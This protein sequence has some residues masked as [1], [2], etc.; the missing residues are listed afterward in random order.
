[1]VI[2]RNAR[3]MNHRIIRMRPFQMI[4]SSMIL[5]FSSKGRKQT[6]TVQQSRVEWI[7]KRFHRAVV[8]LGCFAAFA[9]SSMRAGEIF[10][11]ANQLG[12]RPQDSKIGIAFSSEA[13]P[14][15]FVVISTETYKVAFEGKSESTLI[16]WGQFTNHSELDFSGLRKPGRYLLKMG[17]FGS[18]P[19]EIDP[20][21]Y[22]ALPNELLEFMRE[23]RCG[24]NPWI[25]TV[26][27]PFDGRAV[28]G[29]LTNGTY[30]DARGGWHDAADLLKYL[31]TSGNATAQLLPSI[32]IGSRARNSRQPV[33][34]Q[35]E[36]PGAAWCQWNS[37][38]SGRGALGT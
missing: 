27:H 14:P 5:L 19:F 20:N 25:G 37:G 13:L 22:A 26:C 35:G 8:V 7:S 3:I 29:P 31:L 18:L 23:Q 21:A 16:P 10:I 17:N 11:R 32:R 28:Y 34:R 36:C 9:V 1:M 33:S 24:Y 15:N 4:L 2:P 30:V 6:Q 12:Y 38:R